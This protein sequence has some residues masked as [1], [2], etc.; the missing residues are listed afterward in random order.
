MFGRSKTTNDQLADEALTPA[1]EGAKNRPTPKRRDQQAARRQPLVVADRKEAKQI[2]RQKRREQ[3]ARTRKAL[4]T[5][6]EAGLP[7]RDKGPVRRYIR[8]YVDARRNLGEFLL[9]IML[10][11]LALSLVRQQTIFTIS[12]ALT[13][14]SVLAVVVDSVLM[15]RG[16]KKRI[17]AKFGAD[18]LP[19]GAVAYAVMRVF[20]LRRQR[21]PKP[22]VAR[23]Q[24]PS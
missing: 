14:A 6:D 10:I 1:R 15:W 9:P 2:E 20:Q 11:V 16:L 17:V 5:G 3:L 23:G 8:D 4:E 22:Q 13:W 7:P 24:Y 12:V 21:M 19:R 18:A